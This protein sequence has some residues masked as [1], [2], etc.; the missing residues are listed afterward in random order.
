WELAYQS[1]AQAREPEDQEAT[2][3]IPEETL[4]A[5]LQNLH[6]AHD[7]EWAEQM[8]CIMK[9]RSGLLIESRPGVYR[10]PHRTFQEYLAGCYLS[11]QP[12]FI[13]RTLE[14]AQQP[15]FWREVILLAVGR[16]IHLSGDLDRPL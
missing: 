16:L 9:L 8:T 2:A 11:N 15:A 12:Q 10:F 1:H 4:L 13:E 6:P 14:L 7:P 5:T 3:D